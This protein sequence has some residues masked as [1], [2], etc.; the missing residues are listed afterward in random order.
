MGW[1][2]EAAASLSK[3]T[4]SRQPEFLETRLCVPAFLIQS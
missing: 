1:V 2:I 3:A 4:A